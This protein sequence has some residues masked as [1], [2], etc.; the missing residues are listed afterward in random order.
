MT[1]TP[2]IAYSETMQVRFRDTDAQ[3]HFYFANYLVFA[4]EVSGN[5]LRELGYDWSDPAGVPCMMF[6]ANISCDYL[7]ECRMGDL[8]R[9]EVGYEHLGNSSARLGFHLF[10]ENTSTAL[11]KGS[12]T[13]VFID[14]ATRRPCAIPEPI[15]RA[16]GERQPN[17]T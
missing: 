8:V 4:D 16:I 5:Y 6:T 1:T 3:G 14:H 13:Q 15:R 7:H 10:N 9:V 17:L 12:L 11:A 2:A